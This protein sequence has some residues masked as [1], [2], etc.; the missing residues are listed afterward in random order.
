MFSEPIVLTIDYKMAATL[1]RLLNE[2]V[3]KHDG[4]HNPRSQQRYREAR[5]LEGALDQAWST[6]WNA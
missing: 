3:S 1:K 5:N 4:D 6:W 2:E